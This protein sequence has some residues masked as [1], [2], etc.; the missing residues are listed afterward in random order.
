MHDPIIQRSPAAKKKLK[1]ETKRLRCQAFFG[2]YFSRCPARLI[3][4]MSSTNRQSPTSAPDL[5]S[6]LYG[7]AGFT[8]RLSSGAPIESPFPAYVLQLVVFG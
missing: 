8:F 1:G 3:G 2:D 5:F 4:A 7:E 6:T